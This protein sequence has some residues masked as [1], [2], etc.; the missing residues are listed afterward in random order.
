MPDTWHDWLDVA[1]ERRADV[2][3]LQLGQREVAVIYIVGYTVECH[4]KALL[5]KKSIRFPR[6][7]P[8]GHNLAALME[9]AGMKRSDLMQPRREFVDMWG[10]D[11][12]YETELPQGS[13][14]DTLLKGGTDLASYVAKQIKRDR[15]HNRRNR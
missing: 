6:S 14:F 11:L 7:G 1:G 5:N 12:R 9:K 3:A 8:E 2:T 15:P 13:D 10:T 4:L